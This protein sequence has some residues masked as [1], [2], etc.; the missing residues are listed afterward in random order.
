MRKITDAPTMTGEASKTEATK[1]R[2]EPA[3]RK[4]TQTRAGR[5]RKEMIGGYVAALGGTDRVSAIQ[6][7]NIR[8]AVDL[9]LLAAECVS[10]CAKARRRYP[11]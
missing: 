4:P 2:R 5:L 6:L 11:S 7:E 8:R 3:Y 10:R 9:T 1:S